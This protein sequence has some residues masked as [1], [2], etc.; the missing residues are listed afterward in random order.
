[1]PPTVQLRRFDLSRVPDD[2]VCLVIGKRRTGKSTLIRDILFKK[3]H[4]SYGIACNGTEESN[5][6]YA[7]LMPDMYVYDD[8]AREAIVSLVSAQRESKRTRSTAPSCFLILDDV[9]FE[10]K[11]SS[12]KALKQIL[13]NGRHYNMFSILALQYLMSVDVSMRANFDFVFC[14]AEKNSTIL[15]KLHKNFFDQFDSYGTFESVFKACTANYECLV[16]DNTSTSAAVEDNI[17]YFKA[18]QHEDFRMGGDE[19]WK[20]HRRHYSAD[21]DRVQVMRTKKGEEV[22][23]Q[24]L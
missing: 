11:M 2:A 12:D 20:H 3:R 9:G 8:Y 24:K 16:L 1:M 18:E 14:F 15:Q 21:A 13:Q 10:K 19:F 17:F 22:R 4:L 6:A 23:I 5:R 7:K